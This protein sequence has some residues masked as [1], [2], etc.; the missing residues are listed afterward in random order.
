MIARFRFLSDVCEDAV[1]AEAQ[2][3]RRF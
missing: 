3:R 2:D 1:N